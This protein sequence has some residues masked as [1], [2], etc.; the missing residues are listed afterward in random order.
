MSWPSSVAQIT[1]SRRQKTKM[2]YKN[3][4]DGGIKGL[5]IKKN[6]G[7]ES[8]TVTPEFDPCPFLSFEIGS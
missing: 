2:P 4:F 8:V 3:I 1:A 5:L 7:E 6:E